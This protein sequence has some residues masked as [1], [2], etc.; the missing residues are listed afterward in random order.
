MAFCPG[1]PPPRYRVIVEPCAGAAGYATRYHARG[2]V[3]VEDDPIIAELWRWLIRASEA[4]VLELPDEVPET[5]RD[6]GLAPGPAALIGFWL[7]HGASMPAQ[8]PSAWM[9]QY[10]DQFW[11]PKVRARVAAQV[12]AIKHWT[13]IEGSYE[14]APDMEATWFIDP[15]YQKAGKYY[16]RRIKDYGA[17]GGW[18]RERRGQVIVCEAEG[19]DWMPFEPLG[20][21]KANESRTGGKRSKEVIWTNDEL[22]TAQQIALL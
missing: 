8:T 22:R 12:G 18:C 5:V 17:L 13:L 7:N 15:P 19:A 10:P 3:L 14:A 11:G 9:R 20:V 1:L 6:L 21:F 2:V 16:R 4:D